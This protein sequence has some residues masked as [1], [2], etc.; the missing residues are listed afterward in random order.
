MKKSA[1]HSGTELFLMEMILSIFFL[2]VSFAVCIG[3]FAG[4]ASDRKEAQRLNHIQE[5]TLSV[6]EILEGCD[7]TTEAVLELLPGGT[8]GENT[9]I[10]YFDKEWNLCGEDVSSYIMELALQNPKSREGKKG[11]EISFRDR[12]GGILY[13]T[14]VY[15]PVFSG[16]VQS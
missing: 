5:L 10:Y 1:S 8:E 9:L 13:E 16:E 11:A 3:L 15:Y 6:G 7:G 4:A 14:E 12:E 2:V